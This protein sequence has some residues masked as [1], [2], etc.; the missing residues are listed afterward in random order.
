MKKE[1][2]LPIITE[3]CKV[4]IEPTGFFGKNVGR[5]TIP[6]SGGKYPITEGGKRPSLGEF[7]D[8]FQTITP[9][10]HSVNS[11]MLSIDGLENL[12]QVEAFLANGIEQLRQIANFSIEQEL[13]GQYAK[14]C[15]K[16]EALNQ[17]LNWNSL[18]G[19]YH[20]Q[21]ARITE[22]ND[23][24]GWD[25]EGNP[26]LKMVGDYNAFDTLKSGV[27]MPG[28]VGNRACYSGWVFETIQFGR[29]FKDSWPD[30]SGEVYP[31]ELIGT[32]LELSKDFEEAPVAE[33]YVWVPTVMQVTDSLFEWSMVWV[34]EQ[35]EKG[36]PTTTGF[37]GFSAQYTA[38]TVR[39]DL[40]ATIRYQRSAG[41]ESKEPQP[42]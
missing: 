30:D 20:D 12:W 8:C 35:D 10:T 27:V 9:H 19:F 41:V 36:E 6:Q 4:T 3:S 13:M 18:G 42:K 26:V 25:A 14:R 16:K 17:A 29:R 23:L 7:S 1:E 22:D 24:P 15:G 33:A 34:P 40:G 11:P 38:R 37:W 21:I 5:F 32:D 31:Y 2:I 39:G 28:K